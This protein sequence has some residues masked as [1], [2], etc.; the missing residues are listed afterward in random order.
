MSQET[1]FITQ[2]RRATLL[3]SKPGANARTWESLIG[4]IPYAGRRKSMKQMNEAVAAEAG[5]RK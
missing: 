5:S 4:C 3:K 1:K 2:N